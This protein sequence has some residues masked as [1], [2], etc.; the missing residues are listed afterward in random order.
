MYY[1]NK[2]VDDPAAGLFLRKRFQVHYL[3][4]F[5]TDDVMEAACPDYEPPG[6]FPSRRPGQP[7]GSGAS[8]GGPGAVAAVATL[9]ERVEARHL[10]QYQML[11]DAG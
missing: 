1:H 8:A 7:G 9:R 6:G 2:I 5:P 11:V 4:E 10:V 3:A